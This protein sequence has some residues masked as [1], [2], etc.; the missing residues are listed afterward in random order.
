[1]IPGNPGHSP[2]L[3]IFKDPA[4]LPFLT[5]CFFLRIVPFT[6]PP[7]L[8][9]F[10]FFSGPRLFPLVKASNLAYLNLSRPQPSQIPPPRKVPIWIFS[11]VSTF[12]RRQDVN[13]VALCLPP[14]VPSDRL[15]R[16]INRVLPLPLFLRLNFDRLLMIQSAGNELPGLPCGYHRPTL[17]PDESIL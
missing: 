2:S 15:V 10:L 4:L 16:M 13:D 5:S 14:S 7:R 8:E 17:R 6:M 9:L 1:M 12:F 3:L 11:T